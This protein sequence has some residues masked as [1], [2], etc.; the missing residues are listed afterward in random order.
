LGGGIFSPYQVDKNLFN[1]NNTLIANNTINSYID[2]YS[3]RPS[4]I[5]LNTTIDVNDN[6]IITGDYFPLN[7]TLF[8]EFNNLIED[9]TKYYS[10][11]TLK[12]FMV[13][14]STDN[15]N[16]NNYEEKST[17]FKMTGNVGTF[18]KGI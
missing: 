18:L 7:F 15:D 4:Y 6:H 9:I 8:D 2:N 11:M 12:V 17:V 5:S 10:S 3:S 13:E 1:L 14:N 16:D